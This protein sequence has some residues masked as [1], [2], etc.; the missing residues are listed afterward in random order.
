MITILYILGS[1]VL[2]LIVLALLDIFDARV[3]ERSE[4]V[5]ETSPRIKTEKEPEEIIK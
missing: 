3:S 5:I 2:T 4:V 1:T